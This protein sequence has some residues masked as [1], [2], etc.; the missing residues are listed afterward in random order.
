MAGEPLNDFQPETFDAVLA[1][2]VAIKRIREAGGEV[3]PA[4]IV[5]E[6]E[7]EDFSFSGGAR[8]AVVFI[9]TAPLVRRSDPD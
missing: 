7:E 4:A 5:E 6:L 3:T 1:F 9:M 8:T 2:A